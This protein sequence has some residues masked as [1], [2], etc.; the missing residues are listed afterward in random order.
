MELAMRVQILVFV[1]FHAW[2]RHEF[3][4]SPSNYGE[5]VDLTEFFSHGKATGLGEGKF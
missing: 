3:I 1:S 2:E 5:I 4:R